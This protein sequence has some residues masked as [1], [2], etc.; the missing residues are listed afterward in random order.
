[1]VFWQ[2]NR[3]APRLFFGLVIFSAWLDSVP[4]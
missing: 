2:F 1:M 4:L 3:G